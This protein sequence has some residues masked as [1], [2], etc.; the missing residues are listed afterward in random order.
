M[1]NTK[2]D[3]KAA[4]EKQT[5]EFARQLFEFS[6][7]GI[8]NNGVL[9]KRDRAK[10]YYRGDH[11]ARGRDEHLGN[12]VFNKFAQIARNRTAHIIAKRPKWR[13]RPTQETAQSI[14][15]AEAVHDILNNVIWE[16]MKWSQKGELSV[17]EARDSGTSHIKIFVRA[18]GFPDAI[19]LTANEVIVDPKATKKEHL[20]FWGHVYPM[21]IKDIER[22]YGK[23]VEP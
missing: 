20:R 6:Q 1:A 14:Y 12:Y 16:K 23:R 5:V 7:W 8:K 17:N 4:G 3:S 10:R 9:N 21:S 22:R 19:P 11:H 2:N 15:G 13:F 18:D